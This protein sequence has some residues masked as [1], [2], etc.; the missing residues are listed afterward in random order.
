MSVGTTVGISTY[1]AQK[2]IEYSKR[3]ENT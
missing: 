3:N 1:N 2:R